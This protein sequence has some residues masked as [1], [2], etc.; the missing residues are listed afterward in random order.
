MKKWQKT[1][2]ALASVV[3]LT[4]SINVLIAQARDYNRVYGTESRFSAGQFSSGPATLESHYNSFNQLMDH[5]H[6]N[7]FE[8]YFSGIVDHYAK[9]IESSNVKPS[10]YD[11]GFMERYYEGIHRRLGEPAYDINISDLHLINMGNYVIVYLEE[12]RI[13]RYQF[14][15]YLEEGEVEFKIYDSQM[16]E[17]LS[18]TASENDIQDQLVLEPGFYYVTKYF[19]G[20]D[21]GVSYKL[22]FVRP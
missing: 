15:S 1:I 3:L 14:V 21:I 22:E 4:A 10:D 20:K 17:R 16:S 12:E 18:I 8:S 2:F 9:T 6:H 13:L 5:I 11:N 19:S 7:E